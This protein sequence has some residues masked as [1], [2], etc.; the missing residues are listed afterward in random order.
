MGLGMKLAVDLE[1]SMG[2][3]VGFCLAAEAIEPGAVGVGTWP[4]ADKLNTRMANK[5][6]NFVDIIITSDGFQKTAVHSD[7]LGLVA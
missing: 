6:R 7:D 2:G 5:L 3:V 4:H 1:L